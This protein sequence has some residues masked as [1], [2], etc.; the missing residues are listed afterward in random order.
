[1][2]R[3]HS[4]LYSKFKKDKEWYAIVCIK[5]KRIHNRMQSDLK[6][7]TRSE[8]DAINICPHNWNDGCDYR[9]PKP[10]MLY[11]AQKDFSLDLTKCYLIGD[12]KRDVELHR[13]DI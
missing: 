6:K 4:L 13:H 1:M 7:E 3:K 8:I 11:Q 10:G 2:E 12:D 5:L 9:K